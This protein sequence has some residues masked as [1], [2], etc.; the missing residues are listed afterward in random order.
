LTSWNLADSLVFAQKN[1][2]PREGTEMRMFSPLSR[3]WTWS[4]AV[5]CANSFGCNS[6]TALY[7]VEGSVRHNGKAA[8]GVVVTFH[9]KDGDPITA[10]RP[11]GFTDAEGKFTLMTGQEKGAPAGEYA[12]TFLWP[13]E[14]EKEKNPKEFKMNMAAET[15][16]G[17]DGAYTDAQT[18][19]FKAEVKRG[20]TKLEPFLLE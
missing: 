19:K 15:F 10:I 16:D 7:P 12:V 6:H 14:V 9:P 2:I 5:F 4:F 18:T 1:H 11:I 20:E 8:S 17:L 3:V 13:K